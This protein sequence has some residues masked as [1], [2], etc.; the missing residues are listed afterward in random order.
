MQRRAVADEGAL[1][2][3]LGALGERELVSALSGPQ[4][5]LLIGLLRKLLVSLDE[6]AGSPRKFSPKR[7]SS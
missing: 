6:P 5:E 1:E 4:Q 3:G 2:A 7:P